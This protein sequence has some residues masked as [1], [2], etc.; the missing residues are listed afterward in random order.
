MLQP[1]FEYRNM[2]PHNIE[3]H[4]VEQRSM[5]ERDVESAM[6]R[7]RCGRAAL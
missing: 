5:E 3:P 2:E 6:W 7:A 4:D 1:A